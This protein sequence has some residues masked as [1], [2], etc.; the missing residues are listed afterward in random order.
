MIADVLRALGRRSAEDEPHDRIDPPVAT[1]EDLIALLAEADVVVATRF[2]GVVLAQMLGKPTIGIAYRRSTTDLLVDVGQGA[3]AIDIAEL[4]L[5]GLMERLDA[6]ET[7]RGAAERIAV[8]MKAFREALA[9]Q[10]DL[11]LGTAEGRAGLGRS[12]SSG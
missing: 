6:L 7:D 9:A 11:V 3:Y 5:S 1:F 10:Y 4:T 8:R 2:H 12:I